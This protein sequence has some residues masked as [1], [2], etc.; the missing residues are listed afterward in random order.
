MRSVIFLAALLLMP[1]ISTGQ[2]FKHAVGVPVSVDDWKK[3]VAPDIEQ[4][5]LDLLVQDNPTAEFNA[6]R[7]MVTRG[8][9]MSLR[10]VESGQALWFVDKGTEHLALIVYLRNPWN[11]RSLKVYSSDLLVFRLV[12]S[13]LKLLDAAA[14]ESSQS[15]EPTAVFYDEAPLVPI[16]EGQTTDYALT[17]LTTEEYPPEYQIFQTFRLFALENNRLKAVLDDLPV[18]VS[19]NKCGK[20]EY[21]NEQLLREIKAQKPRRGRRFKLE[22]TILEFFTPTGDCKNIKTERRQKT[23]LYEAVWNV[24]RGRYKTRLKSAA[25]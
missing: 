20:Y 22:L 11:I 1:M 3:Q 2:N 6:R 23:T 25:R 10:V 4:T 9:N 7:K 21:E 8:E 12:N 13:K 14:T 24:R 5:F 16:R 18:L 19:T 17:I 15:P